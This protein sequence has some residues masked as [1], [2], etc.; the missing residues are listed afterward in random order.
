[1]SKPYQVPATW[2][3]SWPAAAHHLTRKL[4][5]VQ[6]SKSTIAA[7]GTKAPGLRRAHRE[8]ELDSPP[9]ALA[10]GPFL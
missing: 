5:L 1:M 6:P 4:R 3:T 9:G 2:T 7:S 10:P 8:A